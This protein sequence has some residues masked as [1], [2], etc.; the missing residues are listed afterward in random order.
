MTKLARVVASVAALSLAAAATSCGQ[1]NAQQPQNQAQQQPQQ[2]QAQEREPEPRAGQGQQTEPPPAP[3]QQAKR[4]EPRQPQAQQA[5]Q[6]AQSSQQSPNESF[7]RNGNQNTQASL[8][9][10]EIRRIQQALEQKGFNV[11]RVDGRLGPKTRTALSRFQ[12]MRRLQQTGIPDQQTLAAL[13]IGGSAST[14]GQGPSNGGGMNNQADQPPQQR[15][16][17]HK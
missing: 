5:Q 17:G 12:R 14:S 16:T 4:P 13:G 6:Q 9:Q 1:Q 2:Q 7:A 3:A 15:P 10:D 8:S 11:G